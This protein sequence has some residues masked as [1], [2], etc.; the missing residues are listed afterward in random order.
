MGGIRLYIPRDN[1]G[2]LH[3]A[4][5]YFNIELFVINPIVETLMVCGFLFLI[6]FQG[7]KARPEKTSLPTID[8]DL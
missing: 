3:Q 6:L 7:K 5:K 2:F 1:A 4:N 8:S